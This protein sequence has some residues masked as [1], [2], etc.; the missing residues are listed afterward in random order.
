M[1][2][3]VS[4]EACSLGEHLGGLAS[5]GQSFCSTAGMAMSGEVRGL[6]VMVG[7]DPFAAIVDEVDNR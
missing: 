6:V 4:R 2:G 7:Q 5:D 3:G 1:L